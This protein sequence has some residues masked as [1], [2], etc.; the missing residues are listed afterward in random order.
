[1]AIESSS[2]DTEIDWE[3]LHELSGDNPE[4]EQE[5]L[6]LFCE[7]TAAQLQNL[8][9]ALIAPDLA[10][11]KAIAHHL[12]GS[13]SNLRLTGIQT[14]AIAIETQLRQKHLAQATALLP[15]LEQ[16]FDHLQSRV[17]SL[18]GSSD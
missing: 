16:A 10:A 5:I 15:N 17:R 6:T 7:D 3:Y 1:M 2:L 14:C 8:K 12:K 18:A 13:A 11:A 9:A 4:F